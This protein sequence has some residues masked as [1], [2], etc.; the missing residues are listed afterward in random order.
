MLATP[1]ATEDTAARPRG[2]PGP[3][4]GSENARRGGIATR[5][6][7]GAEHVREIAR[8]GGNSLVKRRGA[9]HL[10]GIG[11]K[12]GATTKERYGEEYFSIIGKKGG[13]ASGGRKRG[14]HKARNADQPA[15]P[16]APTT[17]D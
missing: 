4:P 15:A 12:G 7:W 9:D 13:K 1:T 2:K 8:K 16:D 5:D 6:R 10:K 11:Q 3:K 17:S 14:A